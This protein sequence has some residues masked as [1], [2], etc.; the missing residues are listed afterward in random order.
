MTLLGKILTVLIL[1]M[2]VLFLGFSMMVYATHTNWKEVA[3][4]NDKKL[5][6][7]QDV[8]EQL[9]ELQADLTSEIAL[10][11]AARRMALAALETKLQLRTNELARVNQEVSQKTAQVGTTIGALEAANNELA[12]VSDEVKSLRDEIRV[13]QDDADKKFRDWVKLTDEVNQMRRIKSEL[14]NRQAPL[15][16]SVAQLKDTMEKLGVRVEIA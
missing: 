1:I 13:A 7:Q 12:N 11:Q 9:R 3:Q 6:A 4:A 8:N 15:V 10:E 5:K 16:A 14:E 2:S